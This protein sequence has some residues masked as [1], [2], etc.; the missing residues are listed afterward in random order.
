MSSESIGDGGSPEVP[1]TRTA[2]HA[3]HDSAWSEAVE[4]YLREKELS[5]LD[6]HHPD[7]DSA[8]SSPIDLSEQQV[9]VEYAASEE[10]DDE[11][12]EP[13]YEARPLTPT[14]FGELFPSGRKMLIQ[15]DNTYGDGDVNL[16]V[17]MH[18]SSHHGE[19]DRV[20]VFHLKIQDLERREMSLRRYCRD[21][22]REVCNTTRI[23]REV[24]AESR[25]KLMRS[26]SSALA[27][28]KLSS[29]SRASVHT[30]SSIE[31]DEVAVADEEE[32]LADENKP[33]EVAVANVIR[34]EFSNYAHIELTRTWGK[35]NVWHE[36]EYWGTKYR[37]KALP[38]VNGYPENCV[39]QL[40]SAGS[41]KSMASIV[42][43]PLT[44]AEALEQEAKGGWI[45]PC[46]FWIE[47][48]E[49][50]RRADIAEAVIATGLIALV[51]DSILR[52]AGSTEPSRSRSPL[53]RSSSLKMDVEFVG[54]KRFV[55]EVFSRK[56][57]AIKSHRSM[58]SR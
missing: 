17:D 6:A 54:P 5:A 8:S 53:V 16:R 42:P 23:Y 12:P 41:D 22:G 15:H 35:G 50:R 19:R 10:D 57:P 3:K 25:P 56:R 9:T 36:F 7:D 18:S 52:R 1:T 45:D 11:E 13:V 55:D 20:T 34:L 48:V 58:P 33:I 2:K 44:A 28:L 4:E 21:S 49:I 46:S 14:E 43:V 47:D 37:W 30:G 27:S 31:E 32:D 24:K 38:S 26:L 51:D 40:Y 39:Y 29:P